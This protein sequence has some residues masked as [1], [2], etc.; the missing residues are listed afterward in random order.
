MGAFGGM[1][2]GWTLQPVITSLAVWVLITL[3]RP[4]KLGDRIQ[5]P[6]LNLKGDVLD[7]SPMYTVLNQVGARWGT[8]RPWAET[9]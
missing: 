5:L 1:F 4:F 9:F 7:V 3:N 8:R 6:G 2:I